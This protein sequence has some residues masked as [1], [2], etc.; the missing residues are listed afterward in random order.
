MSGTEDIN[1]RLESAAL[2]AEGAS[3]IFKQV[4]NGAE[5]TYISTE[6][7]SV[8]SIAEWQRLHA[9]SLGGVPALTGRV[10]VLEAANTKLNKY[11]SAAIS[12]GTVTLSA[13]IGRY[14]GVLLNASISTLNLSGAVAGMATEINVIF[15]QDA[16]GGRWVAPPASVRLPAGVLS[17]ASPEAGSITLVRFTSVDAGTTWF[18]QRLA[19]YGAGYAG[20]LPAIAGDN[21][22]FND[23]GT[24]TAGW[25]A[26]NASMTLAGSVLPQVKTAA[27]SNSSISKAIS[28]TSAAQDYILYGKARARY[29]ADTVGVIWLLNG[30]KEVAV[31]LGS[32]GTSAAAPGEVTLVGTTGADTRN[33]ATALSGFNY[34]ANWLEFALHF[35]SKFLSL[36]MYTRGADGSWLYR[37]RVACDWFSAPNI[38]VLTTTGS[39]AGAWIEFDYLTLCRPN[40]IAIGDSICE[41]KTLFSPN[42][43]LSITDYESTWQRH[44]LIYPALRNNLIVNKGVSGN[45]SAQILSRIAEVTGA[46]P[47][48][49]FLHASSN[50]EALG[51]SQTSR[52]Q[53]IQATINAIN[54]AGGQVVLL[55][56]MYGTQAGADNQPGPDLRNYMRSWWT[57]QMPTLTG[58]VA[59]IDIMQPVKIGDD[60]M[61]P[62]LTQSDGI[63][64]NVQGYTAIGQLIAQ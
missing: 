2:K 52:T 22:T 8:P 41:G 16:V 40:I 25:T 38:Q 1:D 59:A 37:A 23:E 54:A 32:G 39:A 47:R 43:S 33:S 30:T 31:W 13:S 26:S 48:V 12:G 53:N 6:S 28:F 18:A 17:L 27:G 20:G 15:T 55:N 50:D 51:V 29:S 61:S 62:G 7:G 42:P 5:N 9:A 49:V 11:T 35:D 21:A 63:H 56:A 58:V 14:W 19:V 36:T 45:T 46:S 44:A 64:P 3:E 60:F 57:S 24:A 10:A 4:A 34:E